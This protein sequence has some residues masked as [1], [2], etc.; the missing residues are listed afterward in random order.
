[1]KRAKRVP[2]VKKVCLV[3]RVTPDPLVSL[4]DLDHWATPDH[5]DH[6]DHPVCPGCLENK[7]LDIL[8]QKEI[9]ETGASAVPW[10]P[11]VRCS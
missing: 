4:D 2:Q 8:D 9:Q 3:H 5:K 10:D 6:K 1:M 7:A 11:G